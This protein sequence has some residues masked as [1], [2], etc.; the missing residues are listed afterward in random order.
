MSPSHVAGVFW[1]GGIAPLVPHL[2]NEKSQ[3]C[4]G[5]EDEPGADLHCAFCLEEPN[6]LLHCV[7]DTKEVLRYISE[8][9]HTVGKQTRWLPDQDTMG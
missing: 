5:I 4:L 8:D 3:V 9:L 2:N 7:F 6:E 1:L